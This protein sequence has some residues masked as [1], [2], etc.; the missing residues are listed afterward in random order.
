MR[1]VCAV[2]GPRRCVVVTCEKVAYD[3]YREADHSL[4]LIW[5]S[6]RPGK[7]PIRVYR[8]PDCSLFHLT[9]KPSIR[10]SCHSK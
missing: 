3:T 10:V 1:D 4:G 7:K 9:S 6:G 8:C 5:R 2:R